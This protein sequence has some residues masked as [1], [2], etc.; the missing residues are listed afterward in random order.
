MSYWCM[1]CVASQLLRH[2]RIKGKRYRLCSPTGEPLATEADDNAL[3]AMEEVD[4]EN[5]SCGCC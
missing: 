1:P 4:N 2:M 5:C 3:L